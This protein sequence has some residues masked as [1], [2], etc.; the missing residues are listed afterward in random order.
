MQTIDKIV[1][2]YNSITYKDII[3]TDEKYLDSP[4]QDDFLFQK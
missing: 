2:P 4:R 1:L 3:A